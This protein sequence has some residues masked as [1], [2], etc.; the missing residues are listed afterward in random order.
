MKLQD[1]LPVDNRLVTVWR[2]GAGLGG[3]FLIV[4]GCLGLADHP[5]FLDTEGD[6]VAGLSTNGALAILSIVAGAILVV[7]AVIGGNFASYLNMAVGVLFVL[8]GF[9]GLTV[10]G[11]PDANIL[12]FR[13]SNVLFAFIFGV[14]L[15]TFGMYGRVSSH[16]PHDNPFWRRRVEREEPLPS[17]PKTFVKVMNPNPGRTHPVGH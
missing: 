8:S 15:T 13:M 9:Y 11:R 4:F 2:I 16:L 14:I 10:L 17:G 7:G 1:E 5:G 3:I 12:N 6:R